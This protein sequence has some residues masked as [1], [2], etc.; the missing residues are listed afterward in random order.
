MPDVQFTDEESLPASR[1]SPGKGG[2][3]SGLTGVI[4]KI[5]LARD[6]R[7]AS[8]ALV[9]IAALVAAVAAGVFFSALS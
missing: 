2:A 4:I 7:G 8:F 6:A 5:G 1:S 3:P 9:G